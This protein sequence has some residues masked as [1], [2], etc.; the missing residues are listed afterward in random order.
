[1]SKLA[2]LDYYI[3][4]QKD[5]KSNKLDYIP[6]KLPI[7][8][9]YIPGFIKGVMYKITSHTGNGKTQFTKFL[10]FSSII[11]CYKLNIK[12]RAIYVLLEETNEEF[13]DSIYLFVMNNILKIPIDFYQLNGL[14]NT[15]LTSHQVE[16]L[17]K[18]K[19]FVDRI[20]ACI[21]T[22]VDVYTTNGVFNKI[23]RIANRYGKV[24]EDFDT[25]EPN[26]E[27]KDTLF[28]VVADHISLFKDSNTTVGESMAN[29]STGICK[30]I[31][32]KSWKW[33][34]LNV[35]QQNLDS[36]RQQYS[37]KGETIISKVIPS[38]DGLGDNR[39]IVRDDYVVFGIFAPIRYNVPKFDNYSITGVED[40]CL[41]DNLR[42]VYI[43]K[44]RLGIPN[45]SLSL[46]FD[47]SSSYF[48][49]L[50]KS[51]DEEDVSNFIRKIKN[52]FNKNYK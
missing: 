15:L 52:K 40:H 37:A 9:A 25:F 51:R 21:H 46:Y 39:T 4:K 11:D 26:E 10:L 43:L 13:E 7:L 27:N 20:K 38:L 19:P 34:V 47:G 3:D 28:L 33:I 50:P 23:K 5:V 30:R 29:W 24:D 17:Y 18:A 41:G 32:T 36:E 8:R 2:R 49:E 44:N 35:Q 12:M 31:L 16:G 48:T 1:M 42:M 45:K 6:F 22:I 14:S